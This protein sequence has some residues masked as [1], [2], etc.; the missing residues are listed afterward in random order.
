MKTGGTPNLCPASLVSSTGSFGGRGGAAGPGTGTGR[1]A[2]GGW[3][4]NFPASDSGGG[5]A[6]LG[7]GGDG[8]LGGVGSRWIAGA[9]D[10][11]DLLGAGGG[12]GA[13]PRFELLLLTVSEWDLAAPPGGGGGGGAL[14]ALSAPL[15]GGGG[16]GGGGVLC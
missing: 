11:P 12:G 4:A 8:S 14:N 5:T 10:L 3:C 7:R 6:N 15:T 2:A 9:S 16:G 1:E 13:G